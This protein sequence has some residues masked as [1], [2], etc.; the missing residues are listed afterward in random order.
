M[1]AFLL[2]LILLVL[3]FGRSFVLDLLGSIFV[4]WLSSV[5]ILIKVAFTL[6]HVALLVLTYP[7]V[8]S[9]AG[10]IAASSA[11]GLVVI[12]Q[13]FLLVQWYKSVPVEEPTTE[14]KENAELW[15]KN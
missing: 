5:L 8:N 10:E 4:G 6:G 15:K 3:L 1:S 11:L 12:W 14:Q 13:S 2:F 9:I 7:V